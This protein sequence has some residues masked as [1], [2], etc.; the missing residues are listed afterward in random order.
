MQLKAYNTYN[1]PYYDRLNFRFNYFKNMLQE[2]PT[3]KLP[4][5]YSSNRV[6][7]AAIAHAYK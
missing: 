4:F 2:T 3:K 5:F 6:L 7:A 1:T